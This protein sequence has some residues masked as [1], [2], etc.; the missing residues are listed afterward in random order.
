M[1]VPPFPHHHTHTHSGRGYT[2]KEPFA[3]LLGGLPWV[4]AVENF[5]S[6]LAMLGFVGIA[7]TEAITGVNTLQAWGLQGSIIPPVL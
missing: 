2:R 3:N 1:P 5:N 6:R 7:L 4:P